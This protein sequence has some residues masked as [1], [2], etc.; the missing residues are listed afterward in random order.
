M[1]F[2]KTGT[3]EKSSPYTSSKFGSNYLI[4]GG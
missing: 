2:I 4:K 1:D 3:I